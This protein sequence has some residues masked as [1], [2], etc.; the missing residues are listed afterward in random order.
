MDGYKPI[1]LVIVV[2]KD[3]RKG[4][5]G[6]AEVFEWV[7]SV[8]K[9]VM[10]PE[11]DASLEWKKQMK[12]DH[13]IGLIKTRYPAQ[14]NKFVERVI[15][16]VGWDKLSVKGKMFEVA[17]FGIK[18]EWKPKDGHGIL[19]HAEMMGISTEDVSNF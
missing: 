12:P 9:V 14:Y 15:L 10:H 4:K 11:Y 19:Y 7:S 18:D 3:F 16:P 13:D 5:D 2:T 17:G 6:G 1:D 8:E